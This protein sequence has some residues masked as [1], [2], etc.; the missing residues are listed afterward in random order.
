[1]NIKI[2]GRTEAVT[3]GM[4]KKA[5]EKVAKF[6]RFY[7]RITWVDVILAA[8]NERKTVEMT[9][10]VN[11]GTKIVGKAESDDMYAAIDLAVDKVT[12]QLRRHKEKIKSHRPKRADASEESVPEDAPEP[13]YEDVI[14]EMREG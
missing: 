14:E 9:A 5:A 2:T 3:A 8:D 1:L 13:T 6:T 11:R 10:G 12:R 7:D 4:K